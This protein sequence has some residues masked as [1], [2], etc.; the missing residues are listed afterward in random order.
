MSMTI[1]FGLSAEAYARVPKLTDASLA[2]L[3]RSTIIDEILVTGVRC[4]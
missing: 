2:K 1:G 3:P 4:N